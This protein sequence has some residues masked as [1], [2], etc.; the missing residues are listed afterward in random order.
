MKNILIRK[1]NKKDLDD[2]LRLNLALFKKE[3]KEFDKTLNIKWTYGKNGKNY[4]NKIITEKDSFAAVAVNSGKIV[5]YIC[6]RIRYNSSRIM[7]KAELDNIIVAE[8]LRGQ[9]IGSKLALEFFKWCKSKKIKNIL[10]TAFAKNLS[11]IRFYKK[12]GF[13]EYDIILEKKFK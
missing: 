1:A 7:E 8:E 9:K 11:G 10:V 3:F 13:N 4:F 5:G 6:G 2:I 12:L